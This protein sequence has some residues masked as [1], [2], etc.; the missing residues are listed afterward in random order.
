GRA[1][2]GSGGISC[3]S[4]RRSGARSNP[5]R[6]RRSPNPR[7]FRAI[8][9]PRIRSVALSS[10]PSLAK[11][12]ATL[13]IGRR[14]CTSTDGHHH[15]EPAAASDPSPQRAADLDRHPCHEADAE[16]ADGREVLERLASSPSAWPGVDRPRAEA[17]SA[18]A[19]ELLDLS[20]DLLRE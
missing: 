13:G 8:P 19:E 15:R 5:P 7:S 2:W 10:L 1:R 9:A 20:D 3:R 17:A 16:D 18:L 11:R 12:G 14:A 6:L 4:R